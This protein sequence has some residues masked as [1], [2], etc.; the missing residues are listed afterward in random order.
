MKKR[1]MKLSVVLLLL[2]SVLACKSW[3]NEELLR[4]TQANMQDLNSL[5]IK[6][7]MEIK[8]VGTSESETISMTMDM[9]NK[10]LKLQ[11][12]I[13]TP[14]EFGNV[15]TFEMYCEELENSIVYYYGSRDV[16]TRQEMD[17]A[18]YSAM[19]EEGGGNPDVLINLFK[20]AKKSRI[21]LDNHWVSKLDINLTW[22]MLK[23]A[24][25]MPSIP[26]L[27]MMIK[28]G[29]IEK[30]KIPMSLLIDEE[31]NY[32][33]GINMDLTKFLVTLYRN[34]EGDNINGI[35]CRLILKLGNFNFIEDFEIP[36]EVKDKSYN[37]YNEIN[38]A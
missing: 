10:P 26:I 13:K 3:D 16:W 11:A 21:M 19:Q 6:I 8:I 36:Q 9:F 37:E 15:E 24:T 32:I 30:T 31:T 33:V 28:G 35:S 14:T 17:A 12:E 1:L 25:D 38:L 29:G 7:D 22:K 20:R 5:S 2:C 4:K 18:E 23:D 27:E 34:L